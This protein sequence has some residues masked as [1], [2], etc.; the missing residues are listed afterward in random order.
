MTNIHSINIQFVDDGE[1]EILI[2]SA[3]STIVV[4]GL[5]FQQCNLELWLMG[6]ISQALKLNVRMSKMRVPRARKP[7][8][9][10]NGHA[11]IT[12]VEGKGE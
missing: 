1:P 10:T 6:A 11:V 9:Y 8:N 7:N 2:I 5:P 12:P 4:M 3:G